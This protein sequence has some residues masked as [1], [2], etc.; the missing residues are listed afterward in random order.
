[1]ITYTSLARRGA[2][3]TVAALALLVAPAVSNAALS[4]PAGPP[5][6]DFWSVAAP[7]PASAKAGDVFWVQPRADAPQGSEGWNVVY[8]SEIAPGTKKYVSGEIY[9]PTAASS[10]ARDMVLW[11]HETT[12]LP[13]SCAPSRRSMVEGLPA[14]TRVP[15]IEAFLAQGRVVV[16]SDYPGQGL[17]GKPYYMAG[18]PNARASLDLLRAAR[19]LPELQA[20]SRFVQYGWSQG[21]QTSEHVDALARSYAPELKGLGTGLIAPAV[22]IRALTVASMA[23]AGNA[24]YVFMTLRGVQAAYPKLRYGD[25]LT[26]DALE[27][28]PVLSDGCFDIADGG[29]PRSSLPR[30]RDG[31]RRRVVQGAHR[32]RRVPAVRLDAVRDLPG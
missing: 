7:P 32:H 2:A 26:S 10:G 23:A 30:Q 3:A 9:V 11:N 8:V 6:T 19:R 31:R 12:G 13:D 27:L 21:G 14:H 20:S 5:G 18:D 4:A 16:A 15:A 29:F 28:L 1:L 22:R 24:G 17:P 25:F